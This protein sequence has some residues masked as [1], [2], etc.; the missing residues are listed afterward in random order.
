MLDGRP[1]TRSHPVNH[2]K[3]ALLIFIFLLLALAGTS[4]GSNAAQAQDA[5]NKAGLVLQ[6]PD[7]TTQTYCIPFDGDTI[8]GFDLLLKTGLQEKV[9]AYGGLGVEVCQI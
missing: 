5:Q 4:G 9:Q 1:P 3:P 8:S 6:F 7:G 2:R